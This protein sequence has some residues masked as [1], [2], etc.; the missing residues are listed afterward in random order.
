MLKFVNLGLVMIVWKLLFIKFNSKVFFFFGFILLCIFFVL[1]IIFVSNVFFLL[2]LYYIVIGLLCVVSFVVF[3]YCCC[4]VLCFFL[5]KLVVFIFGMWN[6][7]F[8]VLFIILVWI[9]CRCWLIFGNIYFVLLL[10]RLL[11]SVV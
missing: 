9:I 7:N 6:S 1:G 5:W 4:N 8:C 2:V 3:L 11:G 10:L